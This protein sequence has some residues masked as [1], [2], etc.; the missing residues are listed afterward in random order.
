METIA[1]ANRVYEDKNNGLIV[2]YCGIL[3]QLREALATFGPGGGNGGGN[4][5]VKPDATLLAELKEA[6]RLVRKYLKQ[7][8]GSL[9]DVKNKIGFD[10]IAAINQAKDVINQ[11]DET[12]KMFGIMAREVFKKFKA[13]LNIREL[14]EFRD[15]YAAIDVIYKKLQ[16]DRD[17]AD[18]TNILRQ[19]H[20]IVD[21]AI[22]PT[23]VRETET[24]TYDISKINFELLREE[25]SKVEHPHTMVQSLKEVLEK[26][27]EQMMKTNPLRVNFYERYQL[28]I[29][30]YNLEKDRAM[31]EATFEALMNFCMDLDEEAKRG[32]RD[33]LD[34]E[35]LALFDLLISGKKL[36]PAQR[37]RVKTVGSELIDALKKE[38]LR[39]DNWRD[40]DTAKADVKSFI[41]DFLYNEQTGLPTDSFTDDEVQTKAWI[42]FDHV[43]QQY[44]DAGHHA[45]ME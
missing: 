39:I 33:G 32:M 17:E 42:V 12:R 37:N 9:N 45:Y 2:D 28:L 30:E 1:R 25:F 24:K 36:T 3:K 4:E 40:K 5:P 22:E 38:K 44:Q 27:L 35:H 34:E 6:I 10:Q 26:R 11:N 7:Q 29:H 16:E 14:N 13:C 31:I 8:G 43:Y 15:D 23:T 18:I 41:Y 21:E 20:I 19:L